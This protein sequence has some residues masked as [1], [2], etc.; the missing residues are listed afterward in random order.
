MGAIFYGVLFVPF[1]FAV[2][3]QTMTDGTAVDPF[4]ADVRV[5]RAA[6]ISGYVYVAVV[7]LFVIIVFSL[8]SVSELPASDPMLLFLFGCVVAFIL[9]QQAL[10]L[11]YVLLR[12][13]LSTLRKKPKDQLG[14]NIFKVCGGRVL[15]SMDP[16]KWTNYIYLSVIVFEFFQ[17]TAVLFQPAM[18]WV[19]R[20]ECLPWPPAAPPMPPPSAP[21]AL[22]SPPLVEP[23]SSRSLRL[24][25]SRLASGCADQVTW[26][27]LARRQGEAGDAWE[28]VVEAHKGTSLDLAMGCGGGCAFKVAPNVAGWTQASAACR[29]VRTPALPATKGAA[30]WR[31]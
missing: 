5:S 11:R 13:E 19:Q 4:G 3:Q 24:D 2:L 6:W 8:Q 18:P 30:T 23:T 20:P 12:P 25:W 29:P 28:G 16:K 1:I 21:G 9:I 31:C 7:S 27:V 22:L 10:T 26:R 15:S 14:V 17:F